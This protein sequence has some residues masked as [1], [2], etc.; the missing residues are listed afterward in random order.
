MTTVS[1]S[2]ANLL[3]LAF[4][5]S[6]LAQTFSERTAVVN[7]GLHGPVHS[8]RV[9]TKKLN[10]DP[11][12]NPKLPILTPS[13]WVLFDSQGRVVE[14]STSAKA[15]GAV[16]SMARTRYDSA[17]EQTKTNGEV[18]RTETQMGPH[19]PAEI[20]TFS[21]DRLFTRETRAYDDAGNLLESSTYTFD[22]DTDVRS[23]SIY[24][25]GRKAYSELSRPSVQCQSH[26][27][28]RFDR[29][30]N[31]TQRTFLDGEGNATTTFSL[32]DGKLTT[33]WQKA[34]SG[35]SNMVASFLDGVTYYYKTQPNGI[36]ETTVQ[37]HPHTQSN[38]ELTDTE[39][40]DS[41]GALL[42]KLTFRYTRDG[43]GNW[44]ERTVSA[45]NP[46]TGTMVPIRKDLRSVTYR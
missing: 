23:A 26:I 20:K 39:R 8:V 1:R 45:W 37:N 25:R 32:A 24:E 29:N 15:D 3:L 28:D 14:Q 7:M 16:V 42:E 41:T 5:P 21:N 33:Y 43:H 36:L 18:W 30:G 35:C 9:A 12:V 2:L 6:V 13:A 11:R 10:P 34:D 31:I 4:A 27:L 38:L 40:L 46:V 17:G 19:G 44:V 22:D